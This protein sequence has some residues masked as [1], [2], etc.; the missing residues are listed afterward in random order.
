LYGCETL[1]LILREKHRLRVFENGVL[2]RMCG[3]KRDEAT[4]DWRKLDNEHHHN[5]TPTS[6]VR[7]IKSRTV[8]WAG[9]VTRIGDTRNAYKILVGKPELRQRRRW[10]DNIKW[11]LR[12]SG[13]RVWNEFNW[14]RIGTGGGLF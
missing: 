2:R 6:I 13:R 7:M 14:L 9:H 5:F 4:G 1:F 11:I 3:P 12:N 10:E 8:I